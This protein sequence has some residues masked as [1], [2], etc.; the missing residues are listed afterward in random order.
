MK[1]CIHVVIA[2]LL[3][4][5]LP[6]TAATAAPTRVIVRVN[7]GLPALQRICALLRCTVQ[8]GLEDPAGQEF[9]IT[10]PGTGP[11]VNALI[12]T[13]K[14]Q[15]AVL[16]IEIDAEGQIL[17]GNTATTA[18]PPALMDATPV[19]YFGTAVRRGYVRQPAVD[20]VQLARA[21]STFK[22]GGYGIVAIIDTGV[23]PTH[24]ALM[25]VLLPGYD[26]TRNRDSADEKGDI[27]QS[28]AAVID[29]A[30]SAWVSQSTAAVIDQSTAAVIDGP[31]YAAYG[32][33]T[34]V[35]GI[36]HLVAPRATILPLK[37]FNANGRGYASDVIRAIYRAVNANAKVLNM[38]F[39][40]DR[41]SL[42]L[43]TAMAWA[44]LNHVIAVAAA[45]NDGTKTMVY[46]AGYSDPVMGIAS[47]TNNDTRSE[48]SNFGTPLVFVAAPGEGVVTTYPWSTYAAVWGTSFSTPFVAGT[49]AL[50]L[51]VNATADNADAK[52]AIGHAVPLTRDL[53]RGRLDVYQAVAAWRRA[54]GMR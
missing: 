38:S 14:L 52:A 39:S 30:G 48:F 26:F 2:F 17:G 37:A 12:G 3:L 23:D 8:Y 7:G 49:A 19:D 6:A 50:L 10:V 27:E 41:P 1:R 11:L 28:T 32:H 25:P 35:A 43:R 5:L 51:D 15:T 33:G 44:S 36:V 45:G 18:P 9:L 29:G 24:P 47:T 31:Q 46:P 21:Q 53:G 54:L 34:M 22:V 20:I 42:A 16:D 4:A 40:F 13:L